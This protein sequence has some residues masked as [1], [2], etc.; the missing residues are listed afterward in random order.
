MDELRTRSKLLFGNKL[1][2]EIG[3]LIAVAEPGVIYAR[4][5]AQCL[6]VADS[7]VQPELKRLTQAGLLVQ[8][9]KPAGQSIQY[10]ERM[11]HPYWEA[12]RAVVVHE[13]SEPQAT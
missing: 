8:M 2:A 11:P 4:E 7:Q 9:P 12:C 3:A 1:R 6:H 13:R 10:Y 5:L